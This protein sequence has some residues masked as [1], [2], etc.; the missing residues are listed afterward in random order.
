MALLAAG[1]MALLGGGL[2]YMGSKKAA[3]AASGANDANIAMQREIY[4]RQRKDLLPY[5]GAGGAGLDAYMN[6][7]GF[8]QKK[9]SWYDT[10]RASQIYEQAMDT[11]AHPGEKWLAGKLGVDWAN[12]GREELLTKM[13][14][15]DEWHDTDFGRQFNPLARELRTIRQTGDETEWVGGDDVGRF[16]LEDLTLDPGYNFRLSEGIKNMDLSASAAGMN[17][18]GSTL[19]GLNR[20]NQNFASNEFQNAFNRNQTELGNLWGLAGMG[21]NAAVQQG[22]G[23]QNLGQAYGN[24]YGN[25]GQIGAASAMAPFNAI[26]A[27]INTGM[28]IYGMQQYGN[29]LSGLNQTPAPTSSGTINVTQPFT[30]SWNRDI[31]FGG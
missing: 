3:D 9:K 19:K 29:Y 25:Q 10:D 23:L 13:A 28:G 24:Y 11:F 18:S 17:L 4:E 22:V 14:D 30:G 20:F 26:S 1:G 2:S 31:G 21:Q 6:R 12:V 7:L 16:T 5:Q 15:F 27:G 8:T